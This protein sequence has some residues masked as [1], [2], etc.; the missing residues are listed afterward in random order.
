MLYNFGN[1]L[2]EYTYRGYHGK[3]HGDWSSVDTAVKYNPSNSGKLIQTLV[4][5]PETVQYKG[6]GPYLNDR[7]Y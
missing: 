1:R 5:H 4:I 6:S 2:R 3:Q 7:A